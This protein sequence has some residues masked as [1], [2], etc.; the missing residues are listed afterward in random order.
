MKLRT[1]MGRNRG[2][3]VPTLR[4]VARG[5]VARRAEFRHHVVR[6]AWTIAKRFAAPGVVNIEKREI[7]LVMSAKVDGYLDDHQ[8]MLIAALAQG[9]GFRTFFEIGTNRGRTTWTVVRNCPDMRAYTLDVPLERSADAAELAM[10]SDDQVFFRPG[11]ATGEAFH[12]TQEETRIEQ[13][14][15]DSASFD[16][17]PY[18]GTIDL[19]YIDGAHTYEY[20]HSDTARALEMLSPGGMIVWDDYGSNPGVYAVVNELA[21][22]LDRPVYHVFGTRMAIYS[23]TDFVVRRPFDDHASLP[24]V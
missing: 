18:A 21:P 8:R 6:D 17:S 16:F 20:V 9:L 12:G 10:G 19:V 2:L 14:W 24:T 11:E 7:P 15:G 5:V 4:G 3:L 13:L 22:T 23:R 1:T